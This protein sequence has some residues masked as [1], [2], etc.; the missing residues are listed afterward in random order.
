MPV[1]YCRVLKRDVS[2]SVGVTVALIAAAGLAGDLFARAQ[3]ATTPAVSASHVMVFDLASRTSRRVYTGAGIWE[4]PN[5]SRDGR[6]LL[7]NSGGRLYTLPVDGSSG[8]TPLALDAAVSL[9]QRPRLV[10]RRHT[11]RVLRQLAD[12]AAVADLRRRCRRPE[13]A[14]GR[15]GAAQLFPRLVAGWDG[16]SHS[17]GD[18]TAR[19]SISTGSPWAAAWK[20]ASRRTRRTT[21]GP[22][23]RVTARGSTSTRSESGGNDIWRMPHDGAGPNDARAEADHERRLGGLVSTPVA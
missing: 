13:R 1:Q 16:S 2:T 10:G 22:T 6:T 7:V 9:Q 14:A 18:A 17:S 11:A 21:T 4:A 19:S 23:T 15:L 12:L 5:W 8:P 20:S 3:T